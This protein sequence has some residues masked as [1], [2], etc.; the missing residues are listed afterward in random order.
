L[1]G[2]VQRTAGCDAFVG[3]GQRTYVGDAST[4]EKRPL[5]VVSGRAKAAAG[6]TFAYLS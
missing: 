2:E 3:Q 4:G 6:K 1:V 5:D